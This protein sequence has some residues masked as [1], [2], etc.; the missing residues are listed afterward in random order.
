M[1]R[2]PVVPVGV[3]VG[4]FAAAFLLTLLPMAEWAVPWRPPWVALVLLYWCLAAPERVGV[5]AG[6]GSG[7]IL[8]TLV[9]T[10]IGQNALALGVVAW[11]ARRI[12]RRVRLL[13]LWQQGLSVFG[14]MVV[15]QVLVSWVTGLRGLP[16]DALMHV[17]VPLA[18][19]V[20]WPWIFLLLRRVRRRYQVE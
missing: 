18:G 19:A 14:I 15:H 8:D 20:V 7:L 11:I 17:S 13:P 2:P 12:Y 5:L 1:D 16:V 3:I 6:W 10:L 9:G 4:S